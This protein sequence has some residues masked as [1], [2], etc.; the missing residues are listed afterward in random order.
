M[1]DFGRYLVIFS[2]H[3]GVGRY[4]VRLC[5]YLSATKPDQTPVCAGVTWTL[6]THTNHKEKTPLR[7][8]FLKLYGLSLDGIRYVEYVLCR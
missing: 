3:T 1:G 4:L 2:R 7:V 8:F 5:R 6:A